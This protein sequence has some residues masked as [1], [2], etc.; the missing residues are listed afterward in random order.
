MKAIH[1][2]R[3]P[4]RHDPGR[5]DCAGEERRFLESSEDRSAVPDLR[6]C[7]HTGDCRRTYQPVA[8][9]GKHHSRQHDSIRRRATSPT[10][11]LLRTRRARLTTP[12]TG[13]A[14]GRSGTITTTTFSGWTRISAKNIACSCGLGFHE[15]VS[16]V[17]RAVQWRRGIAPG[18][19]QS[20]RRYR[21]CLHHQSAVH[22]QFP[23]QLHRLSVAADSPLR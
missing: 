23:I 15:T 8:I 4:R 11:G 2:D 17:R 18:P 22:R 16:G 6:P 13:S 5:T 9:P 21:R 1:S 3:S 10:T 19:V 12:I 20:C 14:R 7:H